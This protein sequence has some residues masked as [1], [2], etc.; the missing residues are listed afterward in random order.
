M[1]HIR[2]LLTVAFALMAV[3]V[4]AHAQNDGPV[5]IKGAKRVRPAPDAP[6]PALDMFVKAARMERVALSADGSQ[7]AFTTHVDGSHLLALYDVATGNKRAIK[8]KDEPLSSIRFVDNDHL[9]IAHTHTGLR[10]TCANGTNQQ[11]QNGFNSMVQR[12]NVDFKSPNAGPGSGVAAVEAALAFSALSRLKS[13]SCVNYGVTA[14]SAIIVVDLKTETA[15]Q[16]GFGLSEYHHAALNIPVTVTANGKPELVGGFLELRGQSMKDQPTQRA[17]LWRVDPATGAG[18]M[19]DDGGGDLDREFRFPD[20]WLIGPDGGILARTVYQYDTQTFSIQVRDGQ[21]KK[22]KTKWK[23]VLSRKVAHNLDAFAPQMAGLGRDGQSIL[24]ID[25]DAAGIYRYYELSPDGALSEALN[26]GDATTDRPI[27]HPQTRRLAGF[28]SQQESPAY[29][30]FDAGLAKVYAAARDAAPGQAVRVVAMADDP[31]KL[32]ISTHGDV[33]AGNYYYLNLTDGSFID[34]GNDHAAVPPEWVARQSVVS[35]KSRDGLDI[36]AVLTLPSKPQDE[37]LPVVV[38]PH[39]GPY[40]HD[41]L[42]FNWLAQSIASRGFAVLQPNYRGSN[43]AGPAFTAAGDGQWSGKMLDDMADGVRYLAD[44]SIG[45]AKRACIV[46]QGY[47][48]YAAL[49]G[50]VAGNGTYRCA[51]SIGGIADVPAYKEW[52]MQNQPRINPDDFG[53]LEPDPA[54]PRAFKAA[55]NSGDRLKRQ[56]GAGDPA[57]MSPVAKAEQAVPTLVLH[58]EADKDVP[59]Q[60]SR[61]MRDAGKGRIQYLQMTDC[62]HGLKTETCRLQAAQAVTDFLVKYNP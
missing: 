34:L 16:I 60:Q 35:Y 49:A 55:S 62:D 26:P 27:F 7:V 51:V 3:P 42:E 61:F 22:G 36:Q 40:G 39:D 58:P 28:V 13:P 33:E 14:T 53:G 54:W 25:R 56:L 17:Y 31:R 15:T 11:A 29:T 50:A 41:R 6:L 2:G 4:M 20:D 44:E 43:N 1:R 32:I 24:I 10:S 21:E 9:M 18:R 23:P 8:L 37:N 19:V 57:A 52:F 5:V 46:G 38:L 59:P 45:D 30:F 12:P 48:G 47:G